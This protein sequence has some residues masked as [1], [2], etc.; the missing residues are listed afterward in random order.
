MTPDAVKISSETV[1]IRWRWL[2]ARRRRVHIHRS[3]KVCCKWKYVLHNR[4]LT[5]V[6]IVTDLSIKDLGLNAYGFLR[7]RPLAMQ[8]SPILR[9]FFLR[10][11]WLCYDCL[12][13]QRSTAT[14][15][16]DCSSLTRRLLEYRFFGSL[17]HL[18]SLL[19]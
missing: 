18:V 17:L 2:R 13:T 5:A 6:P 19:C 3:S 15:L 7:L 14:T 1:Y 10:N 9:A 8:S 16:I 4:V 11:A 12:A